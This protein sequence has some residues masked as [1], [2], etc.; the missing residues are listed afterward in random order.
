MNNTK[1]DYFNDAQMSK[2]SLP[3]QTEDKTL[4]KGIM[5]DTTEDYFIDTHPM[6]KLSVPSQTKEKTL[7]KGSSRI[8]CRHWQ[9]HKSNG[10][11]SFKEETNT[12]HINPGQ[13][14]DG[15]RCAR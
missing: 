4:C 10:I 15:M 11:L 5:D 1:L 7:H 12:K 9:Q 8:K 14:L 13:L 6:N 2:L 3:L